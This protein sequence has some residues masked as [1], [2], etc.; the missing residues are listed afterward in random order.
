MEKK[1]MNLSTDYP[2]DIDKDWKTPTFQ[3]LPISFEATSYA[4][5]GDDDPINR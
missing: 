1:P 2:A 5:I 4:L 3:T